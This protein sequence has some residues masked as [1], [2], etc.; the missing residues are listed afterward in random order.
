[1]IKTNIIEIC[2]VERVEKVKGNKFKVLGGTVLPQL[3]LQRKLRRW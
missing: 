3:L 1:L 2:L